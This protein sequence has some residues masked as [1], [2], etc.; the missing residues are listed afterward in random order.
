MINYAVLNG[1][2]SSNSKKK[3]RNKFEK[4]KSYEQKE[5]S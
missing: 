5:K 3:N 2:L 4:E 1:F